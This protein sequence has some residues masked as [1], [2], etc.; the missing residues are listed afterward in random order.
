MYG[1]G[2]ELTENILNNKSHMKTRTHDGRYRAHRFL[3]AKQTKS[4]FQ[5][6]SHENKKKCKQKRTRNL[7]FWK[8]SSKLRKENWDGLSNI[9][10]SQKIR[11]E[12]E[13]PETKIL[14]DGFLIINFYRQF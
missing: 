6:F 12:N 13:K 2:I 8:R 9:S 7:L 5:S 4:Q 3:Y 14:P 10:I 1:W 11:N